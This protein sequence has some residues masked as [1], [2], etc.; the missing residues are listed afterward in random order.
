MKLRR[1]ALFFAGFKHHQARL[2]LGT[3]KAMDTA[4]GR[5]RHDFCGAFVFETRTAKKQD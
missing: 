2:R 4:Y 5:T 1:A 3:G